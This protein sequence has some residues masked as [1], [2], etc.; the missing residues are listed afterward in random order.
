MYRIVTTFITVAL[1]QGCV[2]GTSPATRFY[3]L[4]AKPGPAGYPVLNAPAGI[5]V[6]LGP[7]KLP[8]ML[9]R[10]HI[11]SRKGGHE[12]VLA[13]FHH[14]A[15]NL[16]DNIARKMTTQIMEQL[17]TDRVAVYPWSR[18]RT[19]DYQ[20]RIDILRFDGTLGGTTELNGTWTLLSGDGESELKTKLFRFSDATS[21]SGYEHLVASLGRLT[22]MLAG[23]LA[24]EVSQH[25][26]A[27][28]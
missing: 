12:V 14:W 2:G 5:S 17:N 23:E 3:V 16:K 22:S 18:Q 27:H 24:E 26:A 4:E 1:L 13:N 19:L 8:A 9:D 10:P 20:I 7:I 15:D 21:G 25:A 6:G 11:V 28:R